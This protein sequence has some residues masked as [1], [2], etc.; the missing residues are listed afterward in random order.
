MEKQCHG[1]EGSGTIGGE[2]KRP[3]GFFFPP[4]PN[5]HRNFKY[6][7]KTWTD[8]GDFDF[9]WFW[10]VSVRWVGSTGF[11]KSPYQRILPIPILLQI[12]NPRISPWHPTPFCIQK[13]HYLYYFANSLLRTSSTRLLEKA[14]CQKVD[15]KS[16]V[17]I[18]M[19]LKVLN[20]KDGMRTVIANYWKA[21]FDTRHHI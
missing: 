4:D 15:G 8:L 6:Q 12:L 7:L 13:R 3:Q 1:R 14:I 18:S 9:N 17:W 5:P 2:A 19:K 21:N 20:P 10:S 11:S 16:N